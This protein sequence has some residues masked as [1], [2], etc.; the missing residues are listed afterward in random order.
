MPKIVLHIVLNPD[1]TVTVRKLD[2]SGCLRWEDFGTVDEVKVER[3][4]QIFP[5]S[6][7]LVI[8]ASTCVPVNEDS[9]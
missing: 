1:K 4:G 7:P 9:K 2:E 5:T 3:K 6:V 8:S